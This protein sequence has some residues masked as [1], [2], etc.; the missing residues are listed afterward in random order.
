MKYWETR[1]L[2]CLLLWW[3]KMKNSLDKI[4]KFVKSFPRTLKKKMKFWDS[5]LMRLKWTALIFW[6]RTLTQSSKKIKHLCWL[7][8][9]IKTFQFQSII[10]YKVKIQFIKIFNF[11]N[12]K[13]IVLW[14]IK[15]R[16]KT[17]WN[18]I[19]HNKIKINKYLDFRWKKK[20]KC[21]ILVLNNYVKFNRIIYKRIQIDM[22]QYNWILIKI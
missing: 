19:G 3:N 16:I 17:S 13:L 21:W 15:M 18:S 5:N 10:T 11:L 4:I 8:I 2:N 22:R 9:F 12:Y 6:T 14:T 1:Y 20:K 7:V